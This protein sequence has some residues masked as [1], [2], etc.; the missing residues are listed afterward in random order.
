MG[1][2]KNRQGKFELRTDLA[3]ERRESFPGDGGEISGVSLEKKQLGQGNVSLTE[4]KIL[5]EAGAKA[6]KKP[7]GAYLTLEADC[8]LKE[9][10]EGHG[11]AAKELAA[12]IREMTAQMIGK[13]RLEE[14]D[15]FLLVAGLGNAEVTPDSLGPEVTG[16]LSVT[17]YLRNWEGR[18]LLKE[19]KLPGIGA[20]APGVMAQTGMETAEILRGI[21]GEV[22]PSL[23]I[24]IDALAACSLKRLGTTIQLTDTGIHPGSGVGNHRQ[25]LT[26]ES[27]GVPVLAIG[28]PTVIGVTSIVHDTF[29]ALSQVLA[30]C[31]TTKNAGNWMQDMGYEEQRQLLYELLEPEMG[32]LYVTPPDI[33]KTISRLGNVISEGIHRAFLA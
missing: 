27:L 2:D 10:E 6:M 23:V 12:C 31:E 19:E 21:I 4:V 11:Q 29:W 15:F 14:N 22:K 9:D 5:D 7:V 26:G 18:D 13:K 20:I 33:D 25:G 1:Y 17:G 24:A 32:A 30:S 8:L 16:K 28:V 3:L